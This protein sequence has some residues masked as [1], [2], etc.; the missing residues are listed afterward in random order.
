MLSQSEKGKSVDPGKL[1]KK[2]GRKMSWQFNSHTPPDFDQVLRTFSRIF[3][4]VLLVLIVVTSVY[5][6]LNY[7]LIRNRLF[8][9][10]QVQTELLAD[11]LANELSRLQTDL[12]TLAGQA[13]LEFLLNGDDSSMPAAAQNFVDAAISNPSISFLGLVGADGT[14]I[15]RVNP[16]NRMLVVAPET[17]LEFV[18]E[19]ELFRQVAE[20]PA[21]E[22][23]ITEES[24]AISTAVIT[25]NSGIWLYLG[26][27]LHN[28][29]GGLL[30]VM[31][32]GYTSD[33]MNDFIVRHSATH[34]SQL[35]LQNTTGTVLTTAVGAVNETRITA[36]MQ[37]LM[38]AESGL[39]R[40]RFELNDANYTFSRLCVTLQCL[41]SG[42]A[43]A[44]LNSVNADSP[45][46]LNWTAF[47]YLSPAQLS[48]TGLLK[49]Q[50]S[51]WH[52]IGTMMVFFLI[53]SGVVTWVFSL[54]LTRLR[55]R[56][57]QISEIKELQ[58]AFFEKNPSI[59]FVKDLNGVFIL[60][61]EGCRKLAGNTQANLTGTDRVAVFPREAAQVM[62]QQDQQ[63]IAGGEAMEF[64]NKMSREDGEHYYTT[65]RFPMYHKSGKLYAVGGIANEVTDQVR[66]R[67][68]LQESE[69]LLR[70]L[71][72]S[73]PEAVIITEDDGIISLVNK[74]VEI[75]FGKS[76]REL[77][78]TCISDLLPGIKSS[79]IGLFIHNSKDEFE[80]NRKQ[81]NGVRNGEVIFPAEVSLS[82]V[83]TSS[84]NLLICLVRDITDRTVMEARLRQSQKLEAM[85]KL[86][87]GMAHDF[88]NLLGIIMGNIDLAAR[89]VSDDEV[90]QKR[91]NAARGAAERGAE[92]TKRMLAIARRQPLQPEPISVNDVVSEVAGLLPRTLGPDIE[93][94]L[95]LKSGIAPV[96]IDVSGLENVL[97]NLAIN[98]RDAMP[99]GGV[100]SIIS[101]QGSLDHNHYLVRQKF[102]SEGDYVHIT[103]TD[104]G[105]GMSKET[106]AHAFEPFFSTK[107]K[108]K[109]SGLG[110]SMAYGF[111]NQSN[112]HI[113]LYSEEGKGTSVV[114]YLPV[115][116]QPAQRRSTYS[117]NL[118][119]AEPLYKDKTVLVVDDE[120]GLLDVAVAYLEDMGFSVL[121]SSSGN[122]ALQQL[123]EHPDV[124]LL[125]TDVVMPGN[126]NGVALAAEARKSYPDI[127]VV[128][129]SGFP[130]GVIED[131]SG[132]KMDAP[133]LNKP[134]N[135]NS[136]ASTVARVL[137]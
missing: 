86:T 36:G 92:L 34:N 103:V 2:T 56:E 101:N 129:V 39:R 61:N 130:S 54:T 90:M 22:L 113:Y 3:S 109:G 33:I 95:D 87:G 115:V 71:L 111:V 53:A 50:A 73:A 118:E 44:E 60:A 65:L 72:E 24:S 112:G 42:I 11:A 17:E 105:L 12:L 49:D 137:N 108:G 99:D 14:E 19:L 5:I 40:G 28:A 67:K 35:W 48:L 134:Y 84:G 133:L 74:Q 91:L 66:S 75:V 18:G 128:Y 81:M 57:Q 41:Q 131:K 119:I 21:G 124:D 64:F 70:A 114:I 68:A 102:V 31:L 116:N 106:L 97:I 27:A 6:Y 7:Y 29:D 122:E 55:N 127:K 1:N 38:N 26:T 9:Q 135:R 93:M 110:L 77:E 80:S 69:S 132:I 20:L 47:S 94:K 8:L 62:Q 100:F 83:I 82:P 13:N 59:M 107:D 30:G 88:N 79:D 37:S 126:M 121:A 25:S 23:L 125:I 51:E 78:G 117:N 136:L 45:A 46:D 96:L 32:A 15:L 120:P 10:E 98:A 63:V 85:G 58:E 16:V 4:P 123:S 104:S 76:R 52:P 43:R 89:K